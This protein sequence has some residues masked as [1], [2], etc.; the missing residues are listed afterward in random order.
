MKK[1][2]SV[3]QKRLPKPK[4]LTSDEESDDIVEEDSELDSG[5]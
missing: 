4:K 5:I 3:S 2:Y 1:I